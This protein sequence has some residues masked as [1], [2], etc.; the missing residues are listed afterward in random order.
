MAI[1]ERIRFLRKLRGVSRRELGMEIG[2]PAKSAETRMAQYELGIR[3]P[4]PELTE[5]LAKALNVSPQALTVPDIES[6]TGIAHTLFT[7]EDIYGLTVD[8]DNG[9]VCLRPNILKNL[10]AVEINRFLAEWYKAAAKFN[11]GEISRQEYDQ[12]RYNYGG[13]TIHGDEETESD[14]A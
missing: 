10:R 2:F 14:D 4:K 3:A 8:L 1:N 9:R 5:A 6:L 12:W 11:N 7:L 13:L